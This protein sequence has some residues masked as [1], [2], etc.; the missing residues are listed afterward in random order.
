MKERYKVS[1]FLV[2][3]ASLLII[4]CSDNTVRYSDI[5]IPPHKPIRLVELEEIMK[6]RGL[7]ESEL[8]EFIKLNNSRESLR[9]EQ[10]MVSE[11]LALVER[12][13]EQY[14]ITELEQRN[15]SSEYISKY[16]ADIKQ[17]MPSLLK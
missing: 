1:V 16:I 6:K 13:K 17:K 14:L 4:G 15:L 3:I 2:L 9:S 11:L 8:E 5:R 10:P 7:F 12:N